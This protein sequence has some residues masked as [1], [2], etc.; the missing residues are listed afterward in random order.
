MAKRLPSSTNDGALRLPTGNPATYDG[1]DP[2]PRSTQQVLRE[3]LWLRELME[4]RLAGMD[5]ALELLQQF[6][7]STP[8]TMDVQHMVNALRE[9]VMQKFDGVDKTFQQNGTAVSAAL[10]AQEKQA[11]AT[12]DTNR[13]ASDKME[14]AFTK[15]FDMLSASS[16]TDISGVKDSINDIKDRITIIESKTSV[17]DPSTA[18]NIAKLDAAVTRLNSSTDLSAGKSTGMATLWALVLGA[19]G[20]LMGIGTFIIMAMKYTR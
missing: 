7:N 9:V 13:A 1:G 19:L 14:T 15:Q 10:Q 8:T 11:I 20:A 3:N 4:T 16:K 12:N 2:S 5:K 6:A 17:Q 18:V